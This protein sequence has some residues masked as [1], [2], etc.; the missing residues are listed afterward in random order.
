MVGPRKEQLCFI[1]SAYPN[2]DATHALLTKLRVNEASTG[3]VIFLFQSLKTTKD[4]SLNPAH[5]CFPISSNLQVPNMRI[6]WIY[7]C[8]RERQGSK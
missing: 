8:V 3:P 6:M 1:P 4:L 2:H 5:S 7:M